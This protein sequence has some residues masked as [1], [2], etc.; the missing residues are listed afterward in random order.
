MLTDLGISVAYWLSF[1]LA[2]ID[3]GYSDVRWRLLLAFQCFPALL[4][5]VGVKMLPD[6]PRYLAVAGKHDEARE[7][8]EHI[9]GSY[10]A[11]VEMEYLEIAAVAK[12]SMKS[13]P[14][15]FGKILIGKGGKKGHHLGRRAWLCMWLQ[16][17]AS[18]TGI[19]VSACSIVHVLPLT[20]RKRP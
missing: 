7:V 3:G 2:F 15:Q 4:L 16:I 20:A 1:G 19:T 14:L 13:S 11:E 8:L 17:M 6:S 5:L 12:E 10:D 18:W 9:R